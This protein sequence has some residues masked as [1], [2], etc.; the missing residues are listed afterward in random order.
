PVHVL[1]HRRLAAPRSPHAGTR[2]LRAHVGA[3]Q[4]LGPFV[5]RTR[6]GDRRT[7]GQLSADLLAGRSHQRCHGLVTAV[8]RGGMSASKK[9]AGRR[10]VV[11][12][13]RVG[14]V[15]GAARAGGLAVA[16]VEALRESGGLWCGWSG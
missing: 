4:R 8:E 2:D 11:V 10:L 1:V 6:S 13:N 7:V 5:R 16:L 15:R 12:S 14:P 9:S 3:T